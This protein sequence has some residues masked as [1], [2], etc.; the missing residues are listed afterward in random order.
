MK[1]INHIAIMTLAMMA[2]SVSGCS[3]VEGDFR[4]EEQEPVYVAMVSLNVP[5]SPSESGRNVGFDFADGDVAEHDVKNAVFVFYDEE[6]NL[7]GSTDVTDMIDWQTE[8]GNASITKTGT[9]QFTT[10]RKPSSVIALLNTAN[11]EGDIADKTLSGLQAFREAS[12]DNY[13]SSAGGFFMTNSSFYDSNGNKVLQ[14]PLSGHVKEVDSDEIITPAPI[15][16]ERVVAKVS[17]G[18]DVKN[19]IVTGPDGNIA[20][21]MENKNNGEDAPFAIQVTGWGLNATNKTYAPMK[22]IDYAWSFYGGLA[23]NDPA[24]GRSYWAEDAN[25]SGGNYLSSANYDK[26]TVGNGSAVTSGLDLNYCTLDECIVPIGSSVYCF[27]NTLDENLLSNAAAATHIVLRVRYLDVN[28]DG[29]TSAVSDGYVYKVNGEVWTESRLKTDIANILNNAGYSVVQ[30]GTEQEQI[31]PEHITFS[32]EDV[33]TGNADVKATIGLVAGLSLQLGGTAVSG[34]DLNRTVYGSSTIWAYVG[35][36]CYYVVPIRHFI[37]ATD[38][39]EL[40]T[41]YYGV[42]RNH[43]YQMT[44]TDIEGFGEPTSYTKPVDPEPEPDPE[45]EERNWSV[46]CRLNILSYTKVN[47]DVEL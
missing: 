11:M 3:D 24:N 7:L 38:G 2:L 20:Y 47:Q 46:S 26:I 16:V 40:H 33:Y 8:T 18:M 39:T 5:G 14:V 12:V 42:V 21:L 13:I 36:Y 32:L 6:G 44:I 15:Y 4:T 17:V 9:I 19:T 23:W 30:D 31:L 27:E 43:W 34:E 22:K 10:D 28:T 41:G 25:Y 1:R 37:T 29:S 35:G 45:P